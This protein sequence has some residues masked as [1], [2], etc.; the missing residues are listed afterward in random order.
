M[1]INLK[2][3]A[4]PFPASDIEWRIGQSGNSARGI[5]AKCMAY[6]SARA[7][8]SRLD[9]VCGPEN[10]SVEYRPIAGTRDKEPSFIARI[11]IKFGGEWVFKEDGS[12]PSE[13]EPLKGGI[14]GALKRAASAWGVGRYLYELEAGFAEIA[15]EDRNGFE[16]A[17]TKEG[18]VFYWAPPKLPS[19]ALPATGQKSAPAPAPAVAPRPAPRS[20]VAPVERARPAEVEPAPKKTRAALG[21]EII[22]LQESLG[23]SDQDLVSWVAEDFEGKALFTLTDEEMQ[24]LIQTL[25]CE[26]GRKGL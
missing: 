13:F 17:K 24:Q 19:W 16:W 10:W 14:S 21:G 4:E 8:Q 5:W 22:A 2:K 15:Y 25:E 7:V 6:I 23:L 12:G 3:L 26:L 20:P 9:D 1:T 18:K 11:G